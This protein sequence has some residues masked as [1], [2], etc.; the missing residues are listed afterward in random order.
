MNMVWDNYVSNGIRQLG[1]DVETKTMAVVFPGRKTVLH[2]PVPYD[3]Y[4][5]IFHAY[6][7]ERVYREVVEGKIPVVKK[8]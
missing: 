7:P 8:P 3:L 4:A 6:N 1:Y 2:S 5:S